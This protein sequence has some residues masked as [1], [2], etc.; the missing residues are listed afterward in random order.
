MP[1]QVATLVHGK[2]EGNPLFVEELAYALRDGGL[3]QFEGGQCRLADNSARLEPVRL[4]RYA[5]RR[6]CQPH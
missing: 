6:D 5:A 4:S 2:A 1:E 3:L